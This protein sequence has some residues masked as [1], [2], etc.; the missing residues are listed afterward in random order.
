MSTWNATQVQYGFLFANIWSI[1]ED[2]PNARKHIEKLYYGFLAYHRTRSCYYL[3]F[4]TTTSIKLLWVWL[5]SKLY[6]EESADHWFTSM[7]LDRP[8]L[9]KRTSRKVPT[10]AVKM[11]RQRLKTA[12][13]R[14]NSYV[15]KQ[16]GR[17]K[18]Q[19]GDVIFLKVAPL[20]GVMRFGKKGKLSP[21]YIGPFEII[22]RIGKVA[23]KLAL[24]PELS[25]IH[26]V[27]HIYML[28]KYVPDSSHVL[29][30]KPIEVHEDLTYEEKPVK[31]LDRHDKML[32]NKV[33]HFIK[34][35]QRN[36]KIEEA[37]WEREED[38][39]ARYQEL[40]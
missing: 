19:E 8:V 26:N 12:Q 14:Q 2:Y 24:C 21:R 35:L 7:K 23:Y 3:S 20:K 30:Q 5:C 31:I 4:R 18:F 34:V 25:S 6:T 33:I 10:E 37:N 1:E 11:I 36:H 40:F 32:R 13:S 29:N 17:L 28:K 38:M 22:E 16:R 15:Y 27:F 9:I 39:K